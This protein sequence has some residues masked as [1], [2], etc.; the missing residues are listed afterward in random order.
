MKTRSGPKR[1][2]AGIV[3]AVALTRAANSFRPAGTGSGAAVAGAA[4]HAA[5]AELAGGTRAGAAGGVVVELRARRAAAELRARRAGGTWA[6]AA[7]GVVVELRAAISACPC[8]R[9]A[10]IRSRYSAARAH[11]AFAVVTFARLEPG[12]RAARAFARRSDFAAA[13]FSSARSARSANA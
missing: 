4:R 8:S 5:A 7:G 10:A 13:R 6:G 2:L 12:G 1:P 9:A 11:R 3:A